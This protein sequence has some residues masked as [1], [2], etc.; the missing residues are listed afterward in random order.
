VACLQ[1]GHSLFITNKRLYLSLSISK[2]FA[3]ICAPVRPASRPLSYD[4]ITHYQ[5]IVLA[6]RETRQLMDEIDEIIPSWPIE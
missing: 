6:L 2:A 1:G 5:K 3:K 4:D